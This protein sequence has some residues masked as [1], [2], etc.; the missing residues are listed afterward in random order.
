MIVFGPRGVDEHVVCTELIGQRAAAITGTRPDGR[1]V[2]LVFAALSPHERL[3]RA[4]PRLKEAAGCIRA[5]AIRGMLK[6][7]VAQ[8]DPG[9]TVG[10]LIAQHNGAA[11]DR[12]ARH[13]VE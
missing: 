2:S 5:A 9:F 11:F 8:L 4:M 6:H 12:K 10:P 13:I 7:P 1:K 3:E